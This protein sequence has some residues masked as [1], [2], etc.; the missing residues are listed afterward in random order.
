MLQ[1][2][3]AFGAEHRSCERVPVHHRGSTAIAELHSAQVQQGNERDSRDRYVE[4]IYILTSDNDECDVQEAGADHGWRP[5]FLLAPGVF[6]EQKITCR[7]QRNRH[8]QGEQDGSQLIW[9]DLGHVRDAAAGRVAL[10][11]I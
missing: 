3:S 5:H 7:E 11:K 9:I 8:P 4:K 1:P 2:G 6:A 10:Q